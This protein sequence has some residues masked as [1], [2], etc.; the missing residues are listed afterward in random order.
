MVQTAGQMLPTGHA[1]ATGPLWVPANA[2]R[3]SRFYG[4]KGGGYFDRIGWLSGMVGIGRFM[5]PNAPG[6]SV[7]IDENPAGTTLP[8]DTPTAAKPPVGVP[9]VVTIAAV[10]NHA[11]GAVPVSG[12]V[13]PVN[14]PVSCAPLIAGVEGSYVAMTVTGGT[15]SG[16][17]TMVVGT[18]VQI[19]S[20]ITA[21]SVIR[22][23]SNTFNVT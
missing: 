5:V 12:T 17:V 1:S 18:A 9:P 16:N 15:W 8:A 11:A 6:W 23:D 14:T 20:H 13:S 3:Y 22:A 2:A 21:T 10:A 7:L 4:G 19:R